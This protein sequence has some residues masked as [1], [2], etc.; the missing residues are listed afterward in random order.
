M[1][2]LPDALFGHPTSWTGL[3]LEVPIRNNND[4]VNY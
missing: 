3:C 4:A 2:K 1:N